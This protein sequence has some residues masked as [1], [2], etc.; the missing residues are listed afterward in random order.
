M[1]TDWKVFSGFIG[2]VIG[3]MLSILTR[4]FEQVWFGAKLKIDCRVL[5]NKDENATDVYIRF[6][7]QKLMA[8]KARASPPS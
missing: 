6:R 1:A 5:G 7:V 8:V 4:R 2:V 3:W